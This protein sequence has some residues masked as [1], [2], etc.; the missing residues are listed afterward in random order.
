MEKKL[1]IVIPFYKIDFFEE[2]LVSLASQTNQNFN[3]YIG[4]DASPHSPEK[5]IEKYNKNT[6]FYYKRF[7]HNLGGKGKLSEQWE[8]CIAISDQDE[9]WMMILADD[10]YLSTNFVEV[11]YRKLEHIKKSNITLLRFKMRRVSEENNFL[12]DLEQPILYKAQD[13]VWDDECH[14][15][16]ISISENVFARKIYEEKKFRKYPLAWRVPMMMYM[17]FSNNGMVLGINDAFVAIRRSNQQLSWREDVSQYKTQAMELFYFDIINEYGYSFK[18]NQ[19][20][21]F[22]KVY[23]YYKTDKRR[24]KKSLF[25][26]YSEYGGILEVAKFYIRSFKSKK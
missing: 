5:L 2:T 17:D 11:F 13:Y 22:L 20:L 14:K 8:R 12:T 15:R 23:T 24:F 9:E 18:K 10:D 1:A 25:K 4:D 3:V 6:N 7:D 21:K 26:L 16:F 19:N